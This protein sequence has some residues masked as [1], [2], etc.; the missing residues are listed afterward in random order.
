MW[1]RFVT[2]YCQKAEFIIKTDDD[3]VVNVHELIRLIYQKKRES[4]PKRP[5]KQNDYRTFARR[6]FCNT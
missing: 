6:L 4:S 2:E 1:L 3:V 5:S